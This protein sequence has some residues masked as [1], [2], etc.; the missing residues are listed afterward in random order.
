MVEISIYPKTKSFEHLLKL[1]PPVLANKFLP[2]WYKEQKVYHRYLEA[3]KGNTVDLPNERTRQLK[4]CPAVQD[5]ITDGIILRS[6]SDVYVTKTK[7]NQYVWEIDVGNN[8][9]MDLPTPTW[10]W[11]DQ[12][13]FNQTNPL[14]LN[15]INNYGILKLTSPYLFSTPKGYGIE[16]SDPFYHHRRT[17]KLLPGQVET[18]IWHEVNFPFEFYFDLSS[19][20]EKTVHIKAGDPLMMLKPYKKNTDKIKLTIN[21]YDEDFIEQQLRND[22]LGFSVGGAWHRYKSAI[23]E[24]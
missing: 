2:K 23:E 14:E 24:E 4:Q 12:H 7:N 15:G 19:F 3:Q 16:F 9:Q 18:D 21:S 13:S 10:K 5:Y 17:I 6:W 1:Y 20:T 22:I 8:A 11:I